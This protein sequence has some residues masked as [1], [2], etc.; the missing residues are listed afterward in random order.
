MNIKEVSRT[1]AMQHFE[2][3]EPIWATRSV[4]LAEYRIS[5]HNKVDIMYK[6]KGGER[7]YPNP[8]YISGEDARVF[9]LKKYGLLEVREVPINSMSILKVINNKENI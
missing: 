4:G 2:I 8:L 1:T 3:K 7:L 9:K 6:S 5:N